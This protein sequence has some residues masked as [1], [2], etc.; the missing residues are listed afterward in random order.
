MD[1]INNGNADYKY[2]NRVK[3][4]ILFGS[5]INTDKDKIHDIDLYV[6]WDDKRQT[7]RCLT[8]ITSAKSCSETE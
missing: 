6:I 4:V 1:A 5:F 7:K 2:Y 3:D 8:L